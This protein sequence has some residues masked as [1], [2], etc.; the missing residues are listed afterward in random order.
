MQYLYCRKDESKMKTIY[1]PKPVDEKEKTYYSA[2]PDPNLRLNV[3]VYDRLMIELAH[4][5]YLSEDELKVLLNENGLNYCDVYDKNVH[6]RQLLCTVLAVFEAM[7]G[8]I[9]LFR[10]VEAEFGTTSQAYQYLERRIQRLQQRIDSIPDEPV[11]GG[12]DSDFSFI[13]KD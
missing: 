10:S 4:Q 9:D 5:Q 8:D 12:R 7:L 2:E 11:L 6:Y 1:Y 13:F 3:S